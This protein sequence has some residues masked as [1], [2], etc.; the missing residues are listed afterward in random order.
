MI[1]L[2][3]HHNPG[4]AQLIFDVNGEY[5]FSNKQGV[6]LIDVFK[7]AGKKADIVVYS[8]RKDA[9]K[10]Y[11]EQTVKPIKFDVIENPEMAVALVVGKRRQRDRGEAD[12]LDAL[13]DPDMHEPS[14]HF[15]V[16]FAWKNLDLQPRSITQQSSKLL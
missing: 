11:G 1:S 5:G 8:N 10:Q 15:G 6:G 9:Q 3:H 2:T 16:V 12:Y 4:T 14:D 13:Q 7:D